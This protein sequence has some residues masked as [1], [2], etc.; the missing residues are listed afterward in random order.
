MR[1]TISKKKLE[2]SVLG[3]THVIQVEGSAWM[4]FPVSE[5]DW[6]RLKR[7]DKIEMLITVIPQEITV[8]VVA[9]PKEEK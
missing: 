7:G 2:D 9:V 1:Y 4:E 8:D 3:V 6:N 5:D